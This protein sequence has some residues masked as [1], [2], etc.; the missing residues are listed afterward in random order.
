MVLGTSYLRAGLLVTCMAVAVAAAG[1]EDGPRL[2]RSPEA[3]WPQWRGPHRD[4]VT[5]ETGLLARWPPAGPP[6]LWTAKG[7]GNGYSSPV[8]AGG[9]IFITGDVGEQL[10]ITALDLSGKRLWQAAN[11]R[12]WRGSYPG[13]RG[14]CAFA[15]GNLY[16]MNAHGRVACLDPATGNERWSVDVVERF[17]GRVIEWGLAEC[18]LVDWPRV[19]VTAGGSKAS[20]A[21]LDAR[22]GATIWASPPI[23]LSEPERSGPDAP[24]YASPILFT[25]GSLRLIAGCT[26]R[27]V[28]VVDALTGRMVWQRP[29]P[30]RYSVLAMTPVLARDGFLMT[31]PDTDMGAFFRIE[32]AGTGLRIAEAWRTKMD[33]CQGGALFAA[34]RTY[35]ARYRRKGWDSADPVTGA[36]REESSDLAMGGAVWADGR[37]ICVTQD[38]TVALVRPT[39]RG[40]SLEGSFRPPMTTR[41]DLWAHPVVLDGRL[42]VRVHDA[43]LPRRPGAAP[44]RPSNAAIALMALAVM[45]AHTSP[46]GPVVWSGPVRPGPGPKGAV[47]LRSGS[48]LCARTEGTADGVRIVCVGSSD[49]GKTWSPIGVIA[50]AGAGA[51]IGDGHLIELSPGHVL[52]SYRDNRV[53]GAEPRYAIRVAESRDSGRTWRCHSAVAECTGPRG[54]LWSSVLMKSQSGALHCM[55]D[56]ERTPWDRGM[57]RHQWLT[58]K[59][60]DARTRAWTQPVT[61]SRAHNPAHLSRDGMGSIIET[62]RGRLLCVF[63]TV[64]TAPPHAGIIMAVTSEDGGRT[65][66]WSRR[67]RNVVY[68]AA[69]RRFG[70]YCPWIARAQDGRIVCVFGLN[71]GR[72]EPIRGGTPLP[73]LGLDI[74]AVESRDDGATWSKPVR[75]YEGTHRNALPGIVMLPGPD[76]RVLAHW[77]DFD[78]G[79]LA[80]EGQLR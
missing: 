80:I 66:S 56:D 49:R 60:W 71:E 61:V 20:V 37:L 44:V 13:A 23:L 53:E 15:R 62:R 34:G 43:L 69:D 38:G 46:E 19:I 54:G 78:R 18:L 5:N 76:R 27:T 41:G 2:V 24:S 65:W 31:A 9:R 11:G 39:E 7:I 70:A 55:Y 3:G 75:V 25:F 6:L 79:F 51:D 45:V 1:P 64:D 48:V 26:E 33:A 42:Y 28:W 63:E 30:T 35:A 29:L 47:V 52:Y 40:F 74:V 72:P 17:G 36:L 10:R 8:I 68:Q 73:A 57:P 14:A 67:E 16:H 50:S 21:A 59:T 12:A 4:A 58:M 22:T 32:Q 77:L